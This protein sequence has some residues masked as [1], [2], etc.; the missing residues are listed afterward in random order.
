[1]TPE[2]KTRST[3]LRISQG[4][5]SSKD[6]PSRFLF[7]RFSKCGRVPFVSGDVDIKYSPS[8][9]TSFFSNLMRCGSVWLCPECSSRISTFRCSE[10][11][12][13]IFNW[14]SRSPENAVYMLTLTHH[15]VLR[16]SLS[17]LLSN[18]SAALMRF[19]SNGSVK[20]LMK[21]IGLVGRTTTFE[22]T[23]GLNSGWHPHRHIL[24]FCKRQDDLAGLSVKLRTYWNS[25]L[26]N[27]NLHGNVYSLNLQG[28]AFADQYVTKLSR[29]CSLS[30]LKRSRSLN[31]RFSPFA[32]LFFMFNLLSNGLAVPDWVINAYREYAV[33]TRGK[34][35]FSFSRGLKSFLGLSDISDEEILSDPDDSVVL[36]SLPYPVFK[37]IWHSFSEFLSLLDVANT[38]DPLPV[39]LWLDHRGYA[40]V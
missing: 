39:R 36:C 24:L 28:G 12:R 33:S 16:D 19:W 9:K 3:L 31:D 15:H 13:M 27:F 40:Y 26:S 7:R 21:S 22:L 20:R 35:Q 1:M 32:L 37:K 14:T 18:Q 30:N 6:F 4:V 34:H 11:E 38:V 10:L 5:L 25:A 29:E 17:D 2:Q 23:F 8:R